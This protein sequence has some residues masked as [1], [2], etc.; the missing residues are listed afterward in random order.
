MIKA[1]FINGFMDAGKTSFIK[2]LLQ[3]DYF[4]ISGKTLLLLCEEGDEE[5]DEDLLLANN[6]TVA[7]IEN[8]EDFNPEY[9]TSVEKE[10]RPKRVIVEFNGM[11]NRKDIKFPWYWDDVTEIT[12]IDASTF[13]IYSKNMKSMVSEQVRNAAMAVFNRCDD[14]EAKLPSFRRSV[15][16][17]NSNINVVFKNK[18]GEMNPRFDEDLPYNI[19][20]S[21]IEL[22]DDTFGIFYLDIMEDV[23]RYLEKEICLVGMVMKKSKKQLNTCIIGRFA[24]TCCAEDLSLF[25]FICDYENANQL[26]LDDWVKIKA[27]VNKEYTEKFNIWYPVFKVVSL[28]QCNEPEKA[29][30]EIR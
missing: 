2:E 23:D 8:E 30:I 6:V 20:A 28:E 13:E 22:E 26:E 24:M 19:Q 10:I 17:V 18:D 21:K 15:K 1:Y 29:I 3:Q 12:L 7:N 11:W 4:K 25:G 5:Y 14:V 9:I 27:I 16:A